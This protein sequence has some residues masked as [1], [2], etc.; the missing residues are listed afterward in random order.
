MTMLSAHFQNFDWRGYLI[1]YQNKASPH[2][3]GFK[4]VDHFHV[5][6]LK[7]LV[8]ADQTKIKVLC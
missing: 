5:G 8:N 6:D 3:S 1:T 2:Q 7:F 4:I